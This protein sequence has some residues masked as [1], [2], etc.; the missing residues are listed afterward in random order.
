MQK[1]LTGKQIMAVFTTKDYSKFK[2]L[3]GNRNIV[4]PH[5]KR[6]KASMEKNYLFSPILI[7]EKHEIIDGQHRFEVCK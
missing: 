4:K 3:E 5:L 6:L 2:H 1:T 7:N